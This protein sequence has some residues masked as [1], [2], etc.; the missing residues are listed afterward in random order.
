MISL[1]FCLII[2]VVLGFARG[3]LISNRVFEFPSLIGAISLIWLIPQALSL[4]LSSQRFE[5]DASFWLYVAGCFLAAQIGFSFLASSRV[6]G[7]GRGRSELNFERYQ[8]KTILGLLL[9]LLVIAYV[10]A[11]QTDAMKGVFGRQAWSGVITFW[12]TL[13]KLANVVLVVGLI[14]YLKTKSRLAFVLAFLALSLLLEE[15]L[16][17]LRREELFNA[18]VLTL[19]AW[20]LVTKKALPRTFLLFSIFSAFFVMNFAGLIR[21]NLETENTSLIGYVFSGE[22]SSLIQEINVQSKLSDE[23]YLAHY[24]YKTTSQTGSV[25]LGA[26]LV[27]KFTHRYVPG[28]IVGKDVKESLK[29]DTYYSKLKGGQLA[30]EYSLGSTRTGFSDSFVNF[31]WAGW[32]LFLIIGTLLGRAYILGTAGS[33]Y[34]LALYL[35]LLSAGIKAFTHDTAEFFAQAF[36]YYV[37]ARAFFRIARIRFLTDGKA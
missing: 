28:F 5:V 26:T 14:T 8:T 9:V 12:Y 17:G 35:L 37:V 32:L 7:R 1:P 34:Y 23:I 24:D 3:I 2:V 15:G 29:F 16:G 19:G 31:Y 36:F 6:F 22:A 13:G 33:V 18:G 27:N 4:E 25:E 20:S 30:G 21:S 10:S 11:V